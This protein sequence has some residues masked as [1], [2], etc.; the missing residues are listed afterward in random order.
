MPHRATARASAAAA[1]WLSPGVAE[2]IHSCWTC[3]SVW[4]FA[5][6]GRTLRHSVRAPCTAFT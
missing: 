5:I 3:F 6:G 1:T 2:K 4:R